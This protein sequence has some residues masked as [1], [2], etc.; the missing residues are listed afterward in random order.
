M[1]QV[2]LLS[3]IFL[4]LYVLGWIFCSLRERKKNGGHWNSSS[5]LFLSYAIYAVFSLFLVTKFNDIVE[6]KEMK[7]FP[8]IYL[9]AMLW[10]AALPIIHFDRK[11]PLSIQPPRNE[12]LLNIVTVFYIIIAFL[13]I[14]SIIDNISSGIA[15]IMLDSVSGSEL[16][17]EAKLNE[18]NYDGTISNFTAIIYN[19]FAPLLFL[20]LFYYLSQHRKKKWII[21]SLLM[22]V[23]VEVFSGL[24]R[25]L[26]TQTTMMIMSF[27]ISY[28]GFKRFLDVKTNKVIARVSIIFG[29]AIMI[30][31]SA[32]TISR[33]GETE[34]GAGGSVVTYLGQAV[35][36]FDQYGLSANGIR[37]GDRTCN[38]FKQLL[39]IPNTPKGMNAVRAKYSSMKMDDSVFSTFVGDFTL[40]FGPILAF[41]I[42]ITFSLLFVKATSF[43]GNAIPF[44]K[45]ILVYLAMIICMQGGMYLFSFSFTGNLGLLAIL[46]FYLLFYIDSKMQLNR[47]PIS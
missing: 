5:I 32:L 21:I 3:I 11:R 40:D 19:L 18:S 6:Y 46:L 8:L 34:S 47:V 23:I 9:F 10:I 36:N 31:F 17:S 42:F 14:P 27:I 13:Q 22:C 29:I 25:G 45:A 33:F 16:Y 28:F 2:G 44:H 37:H 39:G 35:P 1:L 4:V 38:T 7:L 20:F 12:K 15:A 24:S 30:P 43:K 41:I 26:R